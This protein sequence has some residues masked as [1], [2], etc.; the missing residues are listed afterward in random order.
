M[1]C[2]LKAVPPVDVEVEPEPV[3]VLLLDELCVP[4]DVLPVAEVWLLADDDEVTLLEEED[5]V[6]VV[7]LL[8]PEVAINTP[9]TPTT[10]MITTMITTATVLAIPTIFRRR[11]ELFMEKG[12]F[13]PD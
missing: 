4:E 2:C 8:P 1:S 12:L 3:D 11:A 7:V 13:L 10:I 9:A 5:E 6:V